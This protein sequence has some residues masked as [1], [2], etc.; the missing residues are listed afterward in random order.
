MKDNEYVV[1]EETNNV[2]GIL[3]GRLLTHN[4]GLDSGPVEAVGGRSR[5]VDTLEQYCDHLVLWGAQAEQGV[6]SFSTSL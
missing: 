1:P 5:L 4:F 6:A 2:S 3:V